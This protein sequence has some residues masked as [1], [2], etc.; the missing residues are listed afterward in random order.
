M[1]TER[2]VYAQRSYGIPGTSGKGCILNRNFETE[3]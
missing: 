2:D 3:V 1:W